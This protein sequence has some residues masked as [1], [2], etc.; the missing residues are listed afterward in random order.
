[1]DKC[2]NCDTFMKITG[3]TPTHFTKTCLKCGY[4]ISVPKPKHPA[5]KKG[6]MERL[7][8]K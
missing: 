5:K 2:K 6:L 7:I 1:M 8:G 4:K 3:T